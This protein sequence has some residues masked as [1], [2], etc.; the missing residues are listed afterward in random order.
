MSNFRAK[1]NLMKLNKA[2]I[3][4]IQG[5]EQTLRCLVIPVEENHLFVSTD[6]ANKPK[7]AYLDINCYELHAPKYEETHMIK[8]SLAK[9][10]RQN[11]SEE[12][13]RAMPIIGGMKPIEYEQ[14]NA[15][16]NCDAPFT[17][18]V[19]NDLEVLPF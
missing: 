14:R 18:P 3:M 11:M 5:R 15:A 2:S 10:V 9:E 8:Q 19:T 6:T 16:S 4:Q 1:L 7:S 12:E 17:Q 13:L